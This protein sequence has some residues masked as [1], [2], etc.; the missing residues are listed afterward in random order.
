MAR[1]KKLSNKKKELI[2]NILLGIGLLLMLNFIFGPFVVVDFFNVDVDEGGELFLAIS[3]ASFVVY[4]IIMIIVLNALGFDFEPS[5]KETFG[6][7]TKYKLTKYKSIKEFIKD[8]TNKAKKINYSLAKSYSENEQCINIYM[9][10][11]K[12]KE[13]DVIVLTI[14]NEYN[15]VIQQK[16][17]EVTSEFSVELYGKGTRVKDY[18]KV[19]R[20]I[21]VNKITT[22]FQRV[23]SVGIDEGVADMALTVGI[24]FEKETMYI[25]EIKN[26]VWQSRSYRN[27]EEF[28]E[29]V[30][31]LIDVEKVEDIKK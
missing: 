13:L 21:C 17:D 28:K 20:V 11:K 4:G 2:C 18:V 27:Q 22:P 25:K 9:A 14:A 6:W 19:L 24:S 3:F 8:F 29:V 15:R 12:E 23:S 26:S 1:K 7:T 10:P 31:K 16:E 30:F 5:P